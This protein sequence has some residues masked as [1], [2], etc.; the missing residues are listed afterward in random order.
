MAGLCLSAG[1]VVVV[2]VSLTVAARLVERYG[3]GAVAAAGA[4]LYAM[5]IVLWLLRV[6]HQPHYFAEFLPGQVMTGAGVGNPSLSA[7]TGKALPAHQW[8]S[9]SALSNTARQLGTVLGTALLT[10][11]YEPGVNLA[12]IRAG[13]LRIA[14]VAITSALIAAAIGVGWKSHRQAA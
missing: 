14:A 1:P 13:W 5:G 7:V 6:G 9:G 2:V 4:T 11:V 10:V 12:T 8:G 3:I